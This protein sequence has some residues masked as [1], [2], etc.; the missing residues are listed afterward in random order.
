MRRLVISLAIFGLFIVLAE[1][2]VGWHELIAPWRSLSNPA[3][4]L[5]PIIL[6]GASYIVRTLRVYRYFGFHRGFPAMLRLLLQHNALVVLLPLRMGELAFPVLMRRFFQTPFQRSV[7]ALLWLRLIDLHTLVLILFITIYAMV[8]TAPVLGATVVW[9]LAPLACRFVARR[10]RRPATAGRKPSRITRLLNSLA[11]AVPSSLRRI[12]EDWLLTVAN[13]FVKLLAFGWIVQ[14]FS[15]ESFGAS[16]I[17]AAGGELSVVIPV[18][19]FAGFGTYET[20]V[21]FAMQFVGV[22]LNNALSGAVNLHFVSLGTAIVLALTAQVIGLPKE[23]K[24]PAQD[25][26][27]AGARA[28]ASGEQGKFVRSDLHARPAPNTAKSQ[29]HSKH[30]I[31]ARR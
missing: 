4:L 14:I 20:G 26:G 28:F 29:D 24:E 15:A 1:Q 17:G 8:R 19:G 25:R 5:I 31:V 16:V 30:R 13:W 2:F 11:D 10:I 9:A 3:V 22:T 23:Q 6:I 12:G 7:P 27:I 21:T 18:N